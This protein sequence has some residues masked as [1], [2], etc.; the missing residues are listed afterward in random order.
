M[1]IKKLTLIEIKERLKVINPNIKI[2]SKKYVN[3]PTKLKCKCLIDNNIWECSWNNLQSNHGCP[4]CSSTSNGNRCRL[5]LKEAKRELKKINSNISI[6]SS[7]Y[8][9]NHAKLKCKCL[10]DKNEWYVSWNGLKAGKGCPVCAI[11]SRSNKC[12]LRIEEVKN[13]IKIINPNVEILSVEYT[14]STSRLKCRCLIDNSVWYA[15]GGNLLS[16]HGCPNCCIKARSG[17]KSSSWKGGITPLH[18]Y[19]RNRTI[20]QWKQDSMI[21][22][23][24]KCAITGQRFD[25][26]HHVIGFD[27]ILKETLETIGLPIYQE[28]NLYTQDELILIE[29]KCLAIHYK[30]GLGI[31]LTEGIHK[32]FHLIYGYGN[33]TKEQFEEFKQNK[34]TNEA[35]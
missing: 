22:C 27:Q 14:N 5:T 12:R 33:N 6:L 1:P 26:I 11:V 19:L 32:E 29:N 15:M 16:G 3:A 21:N 7:E 18:N 4:V 10:V 24:F 30:Y 23:G 28:I 31:C 20:N 2:L 13:R 8:I 9:N 34:I 35:S 17:S 25:V